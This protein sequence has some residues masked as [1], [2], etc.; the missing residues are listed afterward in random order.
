MFVYTYFGAHWLKLAQII[1]VRFS[2]KFE[3]SLWVFS[4]FDFWRIETFGY[5]GNGIWLSK[6]RRFVSGS[7][8]VRSVVLRQFWTVYSTVLI[9]KWWVFVQVTWMHVVMHRKFVQL[10]HKITENTCW[11]KPKWFDHVSWTQLWIAT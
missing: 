11:I 4:N 6:L 10:L 8:T 1:R 3:F 2:N 7:W 9:G 5:A